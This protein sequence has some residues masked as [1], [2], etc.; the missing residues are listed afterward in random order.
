M[1]EHP[2][3]QE[4]LDRLTF[5]KVYMDSV[6]AAQESDQETLRK[7]QESTVAAL[8]FKDSSLKYQDMLT[9]A[10]FMKMSKDQLENLKKLRKKPYF[11]RIDYH[12]KEKPERETFYIGKVSLFDRETQQP[13]IL[14]WRSPLANVYY[15][16]RVGDV[17]YEAHGETYEGNVSLKRQYSIEE[18]ELQDFRDIDITTKDD[19]L[20]DSLSQNA[21]HRLTEI[22][23]TIQEE[24]NRVIRADLRKPIVVQGAAGSGKTTIALHRVSY[25]LYTL[26][27]IFS[28]EEMLILAPNRLFIDYM[29]EVLP[30][31]GVEKSRS[32]TY[33]D[34]VKLVTNHSFTVQTQHETLMNILEHS[35]EEESILRM[36]EW[37]GSKEFQP[38]LDQFLQYMKKEFLVETDLKIAGFRVVNGKKIRKLFVEDYSYLPFYKR[39]EKIRQVLMS[40]VRRKKKVMLQKMTKKY[41][42]ELDRALYG[43]KDPDKRKRRVSF[44]LDQKDAKLKQ[45]ESES[46]KAV[47]EYMKQYPND[48]LPTYFRRF[49]EEADRFH[50]LM[51]DFGTDSDREFMRS[52]TLRQIK[53]KTVDA[54]DLAT[55][56]YLHAILY[57]LDPDYKAKKVVMDEAQDYSYMEFVSL[58]RALNTDLFTIV[59]DLAQ[60]IYQYR[61][62]K[63]WK[64]ILEDVFRAPN[65]LTLQKTY[66]TT[67][68]I[69]EVANSILTSMN[70]NLPLAEPVL[71]RGDQ[72]SFH[73]TRQKGWEDNLFEEYNR[74][75]KE[76]FKSFVLIGKT[77][78]ECQLI[79]QSLE[80]YV[81]E[82]S[83]QFVQGEEEMMKDRII[84]LPVYL[85]KGLEFDCVFLVNLN[86]TY[87]PSLLDRKLLY[88]AMT[89]PLHR[90][91]FW[92]KEPQAFLLDEVN[93][94]YYKS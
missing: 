12:R 85:A 93:G 52:H 68:E 78:K 60:G 41:D 34:Y 62:L 67:I 21:D 22:V 25:F 8:D 88:V 57:G 79:V 19:L 90:L 44:L 92:G 63:E 17:S 74:L 64:P 1:K 77:V 94:E 59:G 80:P 82:D 56:L 51:K 45:I 61:G 11:A 2:D 66:R 28:P 35:D 4:E 48:P 75:R 70:A 87:A 20:Q 10:N 81:P 40:D 83:L 16:G 86:E 49:Y 46:K 69:M 3:Y 33:V 7:R 54:E 29:K 89:R 55:L 15:E 91:Q 50:M 39:K 37:K 76:G 73:S 47:R 71:R 42:D 6:I 5:T 30:E 26:Q 72:P 84:I 31:L 58:K 65:Y 23:S 36:A 43:I 9:H 38:V 13:I 18:G 32:T 24:Q 27:D 53:K 14:D